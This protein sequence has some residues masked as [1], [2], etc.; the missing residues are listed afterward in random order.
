[1]KRPHHTRIAASTST[2]KSKSI[3]ACTSCRKNKTRCELLDTTTSP[4]QCH[5]CKVIG[6]HCSYEETLAPAVPESSPSPPTARSN[7]SLLS[8]G[9]PRS[10]LDTFPTNI[11]VQAY[12][13]EWLNE[14]HCQPLDWSAPMLAIQNL[15]KP[16]V[17]PDPVPLPS[18]R[19]TYL[20]N[21]ISSDEI[22]YMLGIFDHKYG[23][24]LNF[25]LIRR[26][27]TG[28][29]DTI[30][31]S[32]ASRYLDVNYGVTD[33]NLNA[34]LHGLTG[35][36][37][38]KII[39]NPRVTESIE[40]IQALLILSLWEP[41]S[42]ENT[43]RDGRVLLASA[44][45]MAMNLRLNQASAMSKGL[46]T[47]RRSE[48]YISAE[49]AIALDEM[50]EHARLWIA[51]TNAESM[52]VACLSFPIGLTTDFSRNPRLCIGTGRIPL[53]HRSVEDKNLVQFPK[54]LVGLADYRD[55]RLGLVSMQATIAEDGIALCIKPLPGMD[56][57]D[58]VDS[59]YDKITAILE[60]LK[61]GR[62]LL[63]PLPV[64][65]DHEQFYFHILH[66]YDGL[67]RLLVLYHAF[68]QARIAVGHLSA[69][70]VWHKRFLPHGSPV[71]DEW[72]RDM[73]QTAEAILVY[74]CQA[75][76]GLLSTAPDVFFHMVTLTVG[77]LVG[78]KFLMHRGGSQLLGA[79]D[80]LLPRTA[81]HLIRASRGTGHLGKLGSHGAQAACDARVRDTCFELRLGGSNYVDNY[82]SEASAPPPELDFSF[83][84]STMPMGTDLWKAIPN[85]SV[86]YQAI[87]E[88]LCIVR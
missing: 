6:L 9:S 48:G 64:M 61:R 49:D 39:F 26:K 67:C 36:L 58:A 1:M 42:S 29:L 79:S 65:L 83:I 63:L 8:S 84:N 5:R 47:A 44:V 73:V 17:D 20:E 56:N 59:W 25:K 34:R 78:V 85:H 70:E 32:V 27:N 22:Q 46:K 43:G 82:F 75:D 53:S 35:D 3:K 38:A 7:G 66:I 52:Q 60:R 24:W 76:V 37:V 19:E 33:P 40:A 31:C 23:P 80:L 11:C 69:G 10:R 86:G 2:R 55:L 74:T 81:T 51:I 57:R 72:G 87:A 77:Y 13:W 4:V 71:I 16:L 30:C 88:N 62:R 41:I 28:L 68:W 50:L 18:Q 15:V 45:S 54:S 21:I 14:D 12:I